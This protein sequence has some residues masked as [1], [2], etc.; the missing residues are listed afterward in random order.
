MEV[1]PP[2][3]ATSVQAP[4]LPV[5][6]RTS[7]R[8]TF[9]CFVLPQAASRAIIR[10]QSEVTL[11]SRAIFT[12]EETVMDQTLQSLEPREVW[13]Y[14]F[15]LC[16][17]PR[18]SKNER[19][20]ADYVMAE[21]KKHG[22]ESQRDEAGN[23]LVRKEA[24]P[25]RQADPVMVLQGHLDMVCEKNEATSHDFTRDPIRPVR[26]GEWVRAQGTTLGA[27][28]G[29][30]V[31]AALAVMAAKNLSHPPLELLFTVD[32]ETGLTGAFNLQ[33]GLLKG[34]RLLNLDTEE[35]GAIYIGCAGGVDSVARRKVRRVAPSAGR[36]AF[37]LRVTGL[38]G[39]HSGVDIHVGR[40]NALKVLGRV[41]PGPLAE[42][43]LEIASLSGGSKRNAIP[44]EAA[45]VV[46]VAKS[47]AVELREALARAQGELR[48]ELG[49]ADP[50]VALSLEP[51]SDAPATVLLGEDARRVVSLL[52]AAPHGV[53]AMTPDIPDLVQTSTNLAIIETG[54]DWVEVAMSHRSSIESAKGEVG[55]QVAALCE[56]AGFERTTG[57]GYPGWK[58][59]LS[60]KLLGAAKKLHMELFGRE[61]L[62][63]AIHAGLECGILG[64]RHPGMDMISFG[65]TIENAHSPSERLKIDTVEPFWRL[66]TALLL[67][68]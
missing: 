4:A 30:G 5:G 13:K 28:N 23:V 42:G 14:F 59:N 24:A 34:R 60:S 11:W 2:P 16:A 63:K 22:L 62:V 47:A 50:E 45:A 54:D 43:K 53:L 55:R 9:R 29:I 20:A 26:E 52:C 10:A 18:G 7:N 48:A 17:I 1:G 27:D 56:L 41:L 3:K 38:R 68:A 39:G 21:A 12:K 25:G 36:E 65:P 61:P 57:S 40:G 33:A 66:L 44:R 64:D 49:K 6:R 19:A 15:E 35:D 58:P 8:H 51:I 32:E 31:A 37:R 46:F 67:R